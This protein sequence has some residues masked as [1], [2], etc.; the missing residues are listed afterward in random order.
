MI[1]NTIKMK[2]MN[3]IKTVT[4][5]KQHCS[6]FISISTKFNFQC[7]NPGRIQMVAVLLHWSPKFLSGFSQKPS[8]IPMR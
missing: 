5:L 7:N 2:K 3:T 8:D 4:L 1:L 6:A